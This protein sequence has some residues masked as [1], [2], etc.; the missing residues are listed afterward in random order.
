MW[1]E[2]P[3]IEGL[4]IE[5]D[6]S[7]VGKIDV[8]LRCC[9]VKLEMIKSC[10]REIYILKEIKDRM[11]Y[12]NEEKAWLLLSEKKMKGRKPLPREIWQADKE[13]W[14]KKKATVY[15]IFTQV[16]EIICALIDR[17]DAAWW[18]SRDLEWMVWLTQANKKIEVTRMIALLVKVKEI[19]T[20][21]KLYVSEV[22]VV[23][24]KKEHRL[25]LIHNY[26]KSQLKWYP[27]GTEP[28]ED[29]AP[30]SEKVIMLFLHTAVSYSGRL[31]T[32]WEGRGC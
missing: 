28:V 5:K 9:P 29:I 10:K 30:L 13:K 1:K 17:R 26:W 16:S 18:N 19:D 22:G 15:E 12:S 25:V 14:K 20:L 23:W 6:Q 2:K 7:L 31:N 4:Q 8:K 27:L 24:K 11:V 21:Q 32:W 3:S